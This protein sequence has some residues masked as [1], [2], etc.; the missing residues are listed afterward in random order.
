MSDLLEVESLDLEGRG[1]A[2]QADGKV[3]FIDEAL[4]GEL[5][6]AQITRQ[7][8]SYNRA[9]L[10]EVVRPSAQRVEPPCP[11]FGVCGGA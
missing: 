6:R 1:V 10:I 8:P 2:H 11:N 4:P 7:K 3:V 5:V 9:K